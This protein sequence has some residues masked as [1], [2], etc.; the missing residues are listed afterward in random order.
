MYEAQNVKCEISA[1][2]TLR[3][4]AR[5][6][7]LVSCAPVAQRIERRPPEP[8][9]S[10]RLAPGVCF[11]SCLYPSAACLLAGRDDHLPISH[12][13]HRADSVGSLCQS[14]AK[15]HHTNEPAGQYA[16]AHRQRHD[17]PI[18]CNAHRCAA[19]ANGWADQDSIHRPSRRYTARH[20][21][22][23]SYFNG[24]HPARQRLGRK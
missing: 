3:N 2:S 19:I 15:D 22:A 14:A 13:F 23:P 1:R 11:H 8:Q 4:P 24:E 5:C 9:T 6:G 17:R 12:A 10:V 7:K 18:R 21:A 16:H 20:C